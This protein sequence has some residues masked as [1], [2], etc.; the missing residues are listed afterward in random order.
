MAIIATCVAIILALALFGTSHSSSGSTQSYNAGFY[1]AQGHNAKAGVTKSAATP[2][3]ACSEFAVG[4][5][6]NADDTTQWEAGCTAEVNGASV[7]G[8][9]A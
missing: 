6:V 8:S 2:A 1:W 7:P 4:A 5:K 9:A 3:K